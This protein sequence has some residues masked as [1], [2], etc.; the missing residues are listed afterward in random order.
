MRFD[1][2]EVME[3]GVAA[4]GAVGMGMDSG[5]LFFAAGVCAT[6]LALTMLSVWL[7]NR[8]DR[9]LIGWMLSMALLG[10]G[11]VIY[12]TISIAVK[13][14]SV[15]GFTLQIIGFVAVYV[16]ARLFV[17]KQT[18]RGTIALL[19]A[20]L[21]L[22]VATLIAIDLDGIGIAIYNLFAAV[23]LVMTAWEYWGT[24]SESP[25]SIS[26]ITLLYLLTALSFAA[27]GAVLL[28]DGKW[29]LDARPNNWAENFN[30]IMSIAGITGIGALS[31]GL[32]QA[33]AARRHRLEART[34]ALTGILN[35]RA[36]FDNLAID[37]INPGDAVVVFDLDRFKSINDQYGHH[38]GDRILCQF[39]LEL[40]KNLKDGDLAA[41]MGGEEFVLLI[42]RAS[43]P[44]AIATAERIRAAFTAS[45]LQAENGAVA[46]T[47]SAGIAIALAS[48]DGF[49]SVFLRADA[50]LYRAK[51]NGRDRVVTELQVVA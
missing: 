24:R 3:W 15:I 1:V 39:A 48:D 47:A 22:P 31:I 9:F 43:L 20:G 16:S 2:L 41:R 17:G 32:N 45:S 35:R 12:S 5:T 34:D 4:R 46:S 28:S 37:R 51:N 44:A 50:A 33:R 21:A 25:V 40:R 23:M 26:G 30:A 11:V 27:C 42:R 10:S 18:R 7:Q 36:L 14:A 29:M 49:E 13:P 8:M 6:A 19:C 38:A